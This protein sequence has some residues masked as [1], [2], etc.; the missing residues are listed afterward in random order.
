MFSGGRA[1]LRCGTAK[2]ER[3][4]TRFFRPA[5]GTVVEGALELKNTNLDGLTSMEGSSL[6][7]KHC[8]H[9]RLPHSALML[10]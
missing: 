9:R 3:C 10:S 8:P 4:K 5:G 1:G 2:V 7:G 6:N